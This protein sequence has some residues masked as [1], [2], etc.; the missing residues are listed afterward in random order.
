MPATTT[1]PAPPTLATATEFVLAHATDEDLDRVMSAINQRRSA[2]SA[3]RSASVKVGTSVRIDKIRPAYLK[4]LTGKIV[5]IE[6]EHATIA[7]DEAS[8]ERLRNRRGTRFF[9]MPD[10]TSYELSGVHLACCF[11]VTT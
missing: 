8:T 6:R 7:L 11:E 10:V 5:R 2:L 9:I 3:V 1:T 4:D